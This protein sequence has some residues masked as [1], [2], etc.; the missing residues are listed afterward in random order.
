MATH[1]KRF[2]GREGS[3]EVRSQQQRFD[4]KVESRKRCGRMNL[5]KVFMIANVNKTLYIQ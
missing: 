3:R 5:E 4:Q 2:D 1:F